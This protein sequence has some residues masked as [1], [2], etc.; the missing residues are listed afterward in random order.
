MSAKE[1]SPLRLLQTIVAMEVVVAT[2]VDVCD[3]LMIVAIDHVQLRYGNAVT[4]DRK[5]E[6]Q[7]K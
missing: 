6:P 4:F 1:H 7:L 2:A 3:S 5:F